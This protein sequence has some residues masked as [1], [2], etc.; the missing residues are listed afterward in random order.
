MA[1][2][3]EGVRENLLKQI[4]VHTDTR[5]ILAHARRDAE[6]RNL[7]DYLIVDVDSQVVERWR[8]EDE[9]PEILRQTFEW[10][11]EGGEILEL[12][13]VALFES[14]KIS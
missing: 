8:P 4:D 1:K 7:E 11:P 10:R 9:R 6:K 14:L 12:D 5:D 3:I 13:L 2:K